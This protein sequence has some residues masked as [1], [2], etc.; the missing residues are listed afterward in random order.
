MSMNLAFEDRKHNI[1]DFP[2]QTQTNVSY[3]V[4]ACKNDTERMTLIAEDLKRYGGDTK[5][6][7]EWRDEC[8][9][10]IEGYIND[11]SLRL[12]VI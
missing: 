10:T 11:P 6:D 2:Y 7:Q 1:I 8:L 4:I 5:H 9:P 12:V 3:E